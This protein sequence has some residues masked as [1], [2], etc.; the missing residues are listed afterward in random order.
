M[1]RGFRLFQCSPMNID[2]AVRAQLALSRELL[3]DTE[4][5][6]SVPR[7]GLALLRD[8][9]VVRST[10]ELALAAICIQ[11]DCVPSKKDSSLADY[12]DSAN[13]ALHLAAIT[14]ETTYVAEL[15][16]VRSDLQLRFRLPDP[17]RWTRVNEEALNHIALWCHQFLGINLL[18]LELP[19]ID[20]SFVLALES[21]D[22]STNGNDNDD[23]NENDKNNDNGDAEILVGAVRPRYKCAGSADI[24]LANRGQSEKG[25][26]ANLSLSGCCVKSDLLPEVGDQVEM[27]LEVNKTSFRVGGKVIH[28][29]LLGA[30]KRPSGDAGIG[31]QFKEMSAGARERL[32]ELVAELKT[33]ITRV[34]RQA[35]N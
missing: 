12:L 9:I 26:I 17:R 32:Q 23:D 6:R 34:V 15:Q 31:V 24:R 30:G 3:I 4:N 28:V 25:R 10:A 16:E 18:E 8:L 7:D 35:T 27:I 19:P 2:N 22:D 29:P 13:K 33:K 14:Q 5:Y 20:S 11:L 1:E 21:G